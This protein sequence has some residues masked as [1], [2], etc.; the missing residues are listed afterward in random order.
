MNPSICGQTA[1]VASTT[2]AIRPR[3]DA[4]PAFTGPQNWR[5]LLQLNTQDNEAGD[6]FFLNVVSDDVGYAFI[7]QD[8][9]YGTF[10]CS[11]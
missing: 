2:P 7:S 10:L 5:L 4:T 9:H 3:G 1:K 8:G 11:R 6:P